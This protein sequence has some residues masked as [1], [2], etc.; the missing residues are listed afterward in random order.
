MT[1]QAQQWQETDCEITDTGETLMKRIY[2][3]ETQRK[4]E[5]T[6]DYKVLGEVQI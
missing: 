4:T 5:K 6:P 2:N 3:L 1:M